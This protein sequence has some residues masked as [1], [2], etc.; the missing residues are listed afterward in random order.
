[1]LH[2]F[3]PLRRIEPPLL[4]SANDLE[5]GTAAQSCAAVP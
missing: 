2:A 4:F 5:N 1:V 3:G